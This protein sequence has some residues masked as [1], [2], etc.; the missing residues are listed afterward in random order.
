MSKRLVSFDEV[1]ELVTAALDATATPEDA[2]EIYVVRDVFGKI[3]L[4]ASED[5]R[6]DALLDALERLS[7]ALEENLGAHG[8]PAERAVLWT[9]PELLDE[10][11]EAALPIRPGTFWVERLLV[12]EDWWTVGE[13]RPES[14]PVRYTLHSVKGGMGRS[15]TAIVLARHLARRGEHVLA[16]DLDIESPGL[17]S[18]VL[19]EKAQPRFG[20]VDW[21][22]EELVGQGDA[23][24]R[25]MV[26]TPAWA[27][28]LPG[29]VWI[30]PAHGRDPGEYL[31]KLGRAYVDTAADPWIARLQRLL[32]NL[33]A[34][35]KPTVVVLESR[36]GLHDVAAATVAGVGAEVMLFAVDSASAWTGYGI[37]FDHWRTHGLAP[38]IRERLSVV[39]A[40]TPEIDIKQ[41]LDRFREN[42]WDLFRDRI[43]DPLGGT[44]DEIDAV[45]YDLLSEDAPHDPLVIHWNRGFAAGAPLRR[46]EENVVGLAYS[47]FLRRFDRL[48]DA[49]AAKEVPTRIARGDGR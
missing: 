4:S 15:T 43:Y 11:R 49:R 21:F 7:G 3:G 22:V 17:A 38:S 5:A 1:R 10:M 45:S 35:L 40:L 23:V 31:S 44:D 14:E 6:S 33:E 41:Y 13:E 25:D 20:V 19:E 8:R 28:D 16:V 12:G 27:R 48:H 36:N 29:A 2:G 46:P 37:L 18:A 30:A 34:T 9:D 26:S 42:A 47:H 32:G 39:S 24:L